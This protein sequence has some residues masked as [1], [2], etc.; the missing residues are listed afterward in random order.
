[1]MRKNRPH[2]CA[3]AS[4][5]LACALATGCRAKRIVTVEQVDEV[6]GNHVHVGSSKEEVVAFIDSLKID[7]LE[8]THSDR[9]YGS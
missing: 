1:M 4:A 6:V 7:S 9:F 3:M 5:I 2:F 8:T